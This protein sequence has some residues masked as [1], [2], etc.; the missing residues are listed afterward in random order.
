LR[1]VV[2][3]DDRKPLSRWLASQQRYAHIEANL[4]LSAEPQRLSAVDRLR[5]MGWPAPVLV[6]FYVL[7]VK[8]CLL[9]GWPGWF[10]ALQR[11]LA[12]T[13]MALELIDRRLFGRPAGIETK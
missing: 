7:L 6:L 2:Y 5:R 9:D 1:G 8:G 13:M 4:L 12:E 3:H 11:L 10:Y